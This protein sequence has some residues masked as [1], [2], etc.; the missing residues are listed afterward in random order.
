MVKL[1]DHRPS[2]NNKINK[3]DE[4]RGS[5]TAVYQGFRLFVFITIFPSL[6][7]FFPI[8]GISKFK[9]T[10]PP[11]FNRIEDPT[12]WQ[13]VLY[14]P[15]G[16]MGKNERLPEY[17][18]DSIPKLQFPDL[19]GDH[20]SFIADC[21]SSDL[22]APNMLKISAIPIKY[23]RHGN[24]DP[25]A[26]WLGTDPIDLIARAM[27]AEENNKLCDIDKVEDFIGTGWVMV[28]RTKGGD[29]YFD[30]AEGR[31]E[32]ALLSFQQ[33]AISGTKQCSRCPILPGNSAMVADP[34][35]YPAWFGGNPRLSY[36]KSYAIALAIVQGSIPDPT[37]GALFFS[38]A[39][40]NTGGQIIPNEDGRTRFKYYIDSPTYTIDDLE[41]INPLPWP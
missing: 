9:T 29:G 6:F 13:F 14:P 26:S 38:D 20:F 19:E 8:P 7:A 17:L 16:N 27:L 10:T 21:D 4:N 33:F 39:Y 36:W 30:Y 37:F 22:L 40:Y 3:D 2:Y 28:N 24:Y 32:K 18:P 5:P 41:N 23:D 31:I 11:Q 1:R 25:Y 34:E 35:S 15:G 12:D